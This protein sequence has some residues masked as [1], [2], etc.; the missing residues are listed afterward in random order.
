V[1]LLVVGLLVIALGAFV[2]RRGSPGARSGVGARLSRANNVV[3]GVVVLVIGVALVLFGL[4]DL[5][6]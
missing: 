2:V 5:L 1:F 4:L 3:S 6:D